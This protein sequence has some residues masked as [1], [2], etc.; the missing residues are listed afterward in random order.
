MERK[1]PAHFRAHFLTHILGTAGDQGGVFSS[2]AHLWRAGDSLS[3]MIIVFLV[4]VLR[5]Q[6]LEFL[7]LFV[8]TTL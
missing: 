5:S 1:K 2:E 7:L 4:L 8:I 3:F 6:S